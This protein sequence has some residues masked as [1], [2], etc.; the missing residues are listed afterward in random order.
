MYGEE[1]GKD[2]FTQ[3]VIDDLMKQ[4]QRK[5]DELNAINN[6]IPMEEIMRRREQQ[7]L[8]DLCERAIQQLQAGV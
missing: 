3:K 7:R 2:E 5:I 8:E 6:G 1:D 4:R